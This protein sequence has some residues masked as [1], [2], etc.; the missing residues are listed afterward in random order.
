[1]SDCTCGTA[2]VQG[3]MGREAKVE[4]DC[5]LHGEGGSMVVTLGACRRCDGRRFII[6]PGYLGAFE[7]RWIPCPSCGTS[8]LA[9]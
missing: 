6:D 1:M 8:E 2:I 3:P 4:P 7:N 5:P 9:A